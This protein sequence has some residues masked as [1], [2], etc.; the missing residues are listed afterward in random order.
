MASVRSEPVNAWVWFGER[1]VNPDCPASSAAP[2]DTRSAQAHNRGDIFSYCPRP[3]FKRTFCT[4]TRA[5]NS[6]ESGACWV[7]PRA[8]IATALPCLMMAL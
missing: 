1:L 2:V 3:L 7:A 5:S 6:S 8:T 4:S